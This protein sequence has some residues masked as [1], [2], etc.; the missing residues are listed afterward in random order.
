MA[1]NEAIEHEHG[2]M[3]AREHQKMFSAFIRFS[4]WVGALA[5]VVL[6]FLALSNA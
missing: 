4:A 2:K 5:A 1:Q 6:V 3:D